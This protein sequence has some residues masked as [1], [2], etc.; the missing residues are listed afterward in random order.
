MTR[1]EPHIRQAV[2]DRLLALPEDW[3]SYGASRI[4]KEAAATVNAL[5]I[6][7]INTGGL[8]IELHAGKMDSRMNI[9]IE[10]GPDGDI[11]AVF[12]APVT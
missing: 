10:V 6:V 5:R 3:D 12:A 1:D 8:Q 2:I 7:P 4:T 9:E 11:E